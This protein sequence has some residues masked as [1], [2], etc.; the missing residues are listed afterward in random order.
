MITGEFLTPKDVAVC[1]VTGRIV[2]A[3]L[4]NKRIQV[5]DTDFNHVMVIKQAG[6]KRHLERPAHVAVNTKGEIIVSDYSINRVLVYKKSGTYS[7]DLLEGRW[8]TP[9]GIAVDRF[10]TLY[11]VNGRTGTIKVINKEG[12]ELRTIL[13]G[14]RSVMH[15]LAVTLNSCITIHTNQLIVC[16]TKCQLYQVDK[17]GLSCTNLDYVHSARGLAVDHAGDLVIVDKTEPVTVFRDGRVVRYVGK[18]GQEPW[19]LDNPRG[20]AVTK[21]GE[22]VVANFSKGNLLVYEH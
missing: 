5:L 19:Q 18:H 12:L 6:Q 8:Y 22:I 21:T 10:D 3:D 20:V 14:K 17:M 2:V 7:R 13:Y 16:D 15:M 1:P 11:I 4:D 9:G